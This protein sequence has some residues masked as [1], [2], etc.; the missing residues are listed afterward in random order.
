MRTQGVEIKIAHLMKNILLF[1][2]STSFSQLLWAQDHSL[3]K[4]STDRQLVHSFIQDLANPTMATD[5]LI[6]QYLTVQHPSEELYDYLDASL[7]EIRINLSTKNLEEIQHISYLQMPKKEVN[8]IDLEGNLPTKIYFIKYQ[9]RIVTS[10]LINENKIAS[11]T[12]V[13]KGNRK[14]HF[15]TY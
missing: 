14:A 2:L 3:E 11:F 5:I 9:G 13:S 1:F 12:L 4:D 8:D 6:S 10:L 7:Q 15:V